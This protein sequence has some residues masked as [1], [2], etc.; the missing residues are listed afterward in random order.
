M[1]AEKSSRGKGLA[2]QA[3][4]GILMYVQRYF[5]DN[6]T[7]VVAKI[8]LDNEPSLKF[9]NGKLGF[10][11]RKRNAC[12]NEVRIVLQCTMSHLHSLKLLTLILGGVGMPQTRRWLIR[13]RV[14]G[15]SNHWQVHEP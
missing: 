12:F 14:C 10:I 2:A 1:I 8:S 7:A 15:T 3:L 4:A 9:F 13:G 11:E 5:A 6:I